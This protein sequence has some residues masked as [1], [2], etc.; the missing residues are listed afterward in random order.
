MTKKEIKA[1]CKANDIRNYT[2]EDDL[3][4]TVDGNVCLD[5]NDTELPV[6]FNEVNGNFDL[7]NCLNLTSLKGSPINVFGNFFC[8]KMQLKS[9]EGA[10]DWVRYNFDCSGN[11]IT[12]LEGMPDLFDGVFACVGNPI[13]LAS[14]FELS[15]LSEKRVV[16][17]IMDDFD[18]DIYKGCTFKD[19]YDFSDNWLEF[20]GI[21]TVGSN[22]DYTIAKRKYTI[23]Q[24]IN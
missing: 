7:I 6:Q 18:F 11:Q 4:I 16:R 1:F 12:S 5:I 19:K 14:I 23:E 15:E 8:S 20:N 22:F 9:L 21:A 13:T 17:F 3:R 2:I 10:P 24:I